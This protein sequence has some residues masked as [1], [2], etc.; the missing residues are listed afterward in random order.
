MSIVMNV[1]TTKHLVL[2]FRKTGGFWRVFYLFCYVCLYFSTVS[3]FGLV[4][5][6]VHLLF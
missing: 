1:I 3:C 5:N 4:T 6:S 2:P